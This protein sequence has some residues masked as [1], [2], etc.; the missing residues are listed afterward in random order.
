[1]Q[2]E[3]VLA[4]YYAAALEDD[5]LDVVV[6]SP[7][8]THNYDPRTD[9]RDISALLTLAPGR[10]PSSVSLLLLLLLFIT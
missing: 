2:L 7:F 6:L 10:L 1:M 8:A 5:E 9:L 4:G 3:E